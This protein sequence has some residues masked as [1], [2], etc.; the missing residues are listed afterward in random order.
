MLNPRDFLEDC[1][2]RG[3]SEFWTAG[4]PLKTINEAIDTSFNY[5]VS[6]DCKAAWKAATGKA[7]DNTQDAATKSLKCPACS[8]KH[9][10][11]WTTCGLPE[12]SKGGTPELSGEGYGDGNFN[13]TC[14]RCGTLIN[15]ALLEVAKFVKDVEGLLA[16]DHPM[17]G[18]ILYSKT[19]KP[20]RIRLAS[21]TDAE[22]TFVN[23]LV[24]GHLRSK[25]LELI[26]PGGDPVTMETVRVMIEDCLK[27][28]NVLNSVDGRAARSLRYYRLSTEARIPIRKMM[29][30]Y[31]GNFSP[32]ALELGGAV[33]RQGIFI[34]KMHKVCCRKHAQDCVPC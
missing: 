4:L 19:G 27:D 10:I 34:E 9:D 26:Q 31:W 25:V 33:L 24:K 5:N 23:R 12:D 17:P 3:R 32:F 7:W 14:F 28:R 30:H 8:E 2:R 16:K 6:E 29:A 15:G 22:Q 13:Y 11:P 21:F 20:E 1:I 18:T